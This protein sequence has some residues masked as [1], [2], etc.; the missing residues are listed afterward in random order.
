MNV[1]FQADNDLGDSIRTSVIATSSP[2]SAARAGTQL[3]D[4][5]HAFEIG[6]FLGTFRFSFCGASANLM[7]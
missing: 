4:L 3:I 7:P 6:F 1:R 5:R 2:A